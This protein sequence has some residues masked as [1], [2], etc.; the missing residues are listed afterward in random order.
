[1]QLTFSVLRQS[2]ST[3]VYSRLICLCGSAKCVKTVLFM[4][5]SCLRERPAGRAVEAREDDGESFL[6]MMMMPVP[7]DSNSSHGLRGEQSPV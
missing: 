6:M 7:S 4:L 5:N 2:A 3:S 1:M